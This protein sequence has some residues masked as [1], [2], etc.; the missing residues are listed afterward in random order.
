MWDW[1]VGVW[2]P[3]HLPHGNKTF[4]KRGSSDGHLSTEAWA[5]RAEALGEHRGLVETMLTWMG[6]VDLRGLLA[7][8][9][10]ELGVQ[11]GEQTG[12]L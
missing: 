5:H 6:K 7:T 11:T 10:A 4:W 12:L 2:R 8:L 3:R 9:N 1:A